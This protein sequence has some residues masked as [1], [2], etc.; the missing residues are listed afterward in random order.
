MQTDE[1]IQSLTKDLRPAGSNAM[2]WG[3]VKPMLLGCL[4]TLAV[5]VVFYGLRK[6]LGPIWRDWPTV[7]KLTYALSMMVGAWQLC[8]KLARPD[9]KPALLWLLPLLPVLMLVG[10][11]AHT[12]WQAPHEIRHQLWL[13]HSALICPFNIGLLSLPIFAGLVRGLKRA[14]PTHLRLTAAVAGLMSGATAILF[15]SLFCTETSVP[16]VASWYTVGMLLPAAY[17]ALMGE[18]LLRWR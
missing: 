15:Y 4:G 16:F 10:V 6:D 8:E 18:R 11:A 7:M 1:L 14:A 13:G 9:G 3:L 5:F 12:L 17:G 2:T